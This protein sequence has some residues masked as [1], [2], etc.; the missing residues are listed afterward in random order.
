MDKIIS[1][2]EQNGIK[3]NN[4]DLYVEAFTHS[5][6]NGTSKVRHKDYER[7][8]FLG[9]S[10]VG[11]IVS[12]ISYHDHPEMDQGDLSIVKARFIRTES[13]ASYALKWGFDKLI[14]V[15]P[16]FQGEPSKNLSIMEDVFESFMGALL[17]DQGLSFAHDWLY[18]RMEEDI[19]STSAEQN[20]NPKSILQEV[21]QADHKESV[22]YRILEEQGPSHDKFF[23]A[24]VFFEEHELGRGEGKSKK[25]AEVKAAKDALGKLAQGRDDGT[26]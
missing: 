22:T 5:S 20:D 4:V 26:I 6:V 14:T 12:E 21:I 16:S 2:L 8:E 9:D 17:L 11:L 24:G 18:E 13:E 10:L 19:L 15:G 1:F 7:L 23:V 3:P 25:E